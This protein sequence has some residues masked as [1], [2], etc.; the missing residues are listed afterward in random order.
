MA[1]SAKISITSFYVVCLSLDSMAYTI[2]KAGISF[3]PF[4]S[5]YGLKVIFEEGTFGDESV[6]LHFKVCTTLCY[7]STTFS[8]SL[9]SASVHGC[10]LFC[11]TIFILRYKQYILLLYLFFNRLLK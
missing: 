2:P 9:H 10:Q 5:K 8:R 6:I 11:F 3:S 7:F 1:I 4:D